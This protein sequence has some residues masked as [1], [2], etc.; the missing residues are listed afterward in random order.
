MIAADR[1]AHIFVEVADTLTDD[2]DLIEFLQGLTARSSDLLG[3]SA[4]GLLLADHN[5][6]LQLMAASD[7]RTQ[8]LELFQLQAHEGP[9]HECFSTGRAI[10]AADL[11]NAQDRWPRWAPQ[12]VHHGFRAVHAFPMRLRSEV[13]GALNLFSTDPG[14]IDPADARIVQALAD[15]ATIALIQERAIRQGEILTEQLQGALNA[16]ITIEQAKGALAHIHDCSMDEAYELLR[17]FAREAG[18][19]ISDVALDV[20]VRPGSLPELTSP[21]ATDAD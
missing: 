3:I 17:V 4:A 19:P 7:E 2:F 1:L 5:G 8:M 13:I 14:T 11:T 15:I 10:V 12:A 18:R 20:T 16:R 9:C 21:S 6:R